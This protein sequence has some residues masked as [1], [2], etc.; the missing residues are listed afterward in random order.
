MIPPG[1]ALSDLK[2][3]LI[4]GPERQ[5]G[6]CSTPEP[7]AEGLDALRGL[8]IL[9]MLLSGQLPFGSHALPAWM[10]H[11]QLPPPQ[12]VFR[13]DLPG[14]T[15]V[16]LVFPFF[17]FSLGAAIPLALARRIERGDSHWK[18]IA[19]I[20]GRGFFLAFFAIYVQAIRPH[21]ISKHPTTA[22]QFIAI[23]AF[24]L[25]FA[26][27][28]RLPQIWPCCVNWSIRLVGW[29]GAIALLML[30]RYPGD[31]GF[32]PSRNDIIIVVL[33]NMAVFGSFCWW[34]TRNN[35]LLRLGILAVLFAIRLSHLPT[36][37]PGWVHDLWEWSPAK[38]IYQFYYCQYLFI[39]VPGTIVGDMLLNWMKR[40]LRVQKANW[41][42]A[43]LAGIVVIM[44]AFVFLL[45]VGLKTR[46]L[47]LTTTTTFGLCGLG[48]WQM[49]R[50]GDDTEELFQ[51]LFYWAI[52]WLVLGM[53]FEPY[54]GGIKKDHATVSYYF[55][56]LGLAICV[57]I[58][59]MILVD[60]LKER[61]C[62][63]F[64]IDNG[65]NPMIA[66]AGINNLI[67]PLLAITSIDTMLTK[68]P[69]SPWMGLA[70]GLFITLLV[71]IVVS[72]CT[73]RKIMWRS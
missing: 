37:T 69:I 24:G 23:V 72:F 5:I 27:F 18:V 28:T 36:A 14:I 25:L 52:Y 10:Y 41:S 71:G 68:M 20:L 19:F 58:A 54:E 42:P 47:G 13:G 46:W 44:I 11:A 60:V 34:M 2:C 62:A 16:D 50:P 65:K 22:T 51:T 55:V 17:L 12:H 26:I 56:T 39:V 53:F 57:L 63:A 8:A 1:V 7:R 59:F 29:A 15:W 35:I 3:Q 49:R 61:R 9:A 67:L 6:I 66:Y 21:V 30:L 32:S 73:R 38:W 33:A 48:A 31:A 45:L 40:D 43:R 70:K 4:Q 64:L